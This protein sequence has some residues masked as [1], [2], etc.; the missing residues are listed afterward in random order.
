[1]LYKAT[2]AA[3]HSI[4]FK[5]LS[6]IFL[7]KLTS[8]C[9]FFS[10][11]PLKD[12]GMCSQPLAVLSLF[13]WKILCMRIAGW[14]CSGNDLGSVQGCAP[15]LQCWQKG[16]RWRRAEPLLVALNDSTAWLS[17][18]S[19]ALLCFETRYTW[20]AFSLCSAKS[21]EN[22]LALFCCCYWGYADTT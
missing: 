22:E 2:Q 11:S 6:W 5:I 13:F 3:S 16:A 4:T 17:S 9:L 1:M 18:N 12:L 14:K 15:L 19:H 7:T 20:L 10:L 21:G 8:P